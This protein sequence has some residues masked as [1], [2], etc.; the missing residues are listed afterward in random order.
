MAEKLVRIGGAS[1]FWGDTAY[2]AQ[3]LIEQAEIDYLVF[4][5]LAEITMSLLARAKARKPDSGYAPDFVA[6]LTPL[7]PKIA[8][9]GIKV[10]SNAG[11]VNP[12]ACRDA[13]ASKL[14]DAG[15]NL[16]VAVVLGDDISSMADTLRAE[17]VREMATGAPMPEALMSANAYLGARPIAQALDAGADIVITGRCVDSAVTLGPLMHEFGWADTDYDL[18]SAGSL[19]GHL[20]ECGPQVTG[21]LF[22]DWQSVP[23]WDDMG[24]PIVACASDGSF[25]LTKPDGTG[26]LV[27]PAS[28][29][30]QLVYE[31]GDPKAYILPDVVC[32][33]SGV[34]I[35]QAGADIVRVTGAKGR[36]ST[37]SYKVTATYP[38]GF[39][40][41]AT[42][43]IGGI[44]AEKKAQRVADALIARTRRLFAGR[45]LGDY[46]D[47]DVEIL[48][49]EATYG[50]HAR[51]QK[52]RE[53]IL[54]LAA[55]H[56]DKEALALFTREFLP[57]A[58]SMAPGI[59]GFAGGRPTVSPVVRLFSCLIDKRRVPVT[60]AD[61]SGA[62]SEIAVT[63]G[64]PLK[65]E[66]APASEN[67]TLT[68]DGPS[69]T[70]PLIALAHGR[71]GDKGDDANIGIIAR[72]PGFVPLLRAAL[73]EQ[74]VA[75]Y[76]AHILT[77]TVERYELPGINA[78]NFLLHGALGGGGIASLRYDPQGKAFA[79]MILDMPIAV[80]S[81][82]LKTG[83]LLA[84]AAR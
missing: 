7:L 57:S 37:P 5:Y 69:E 47:V 84:E 54:K 10:V 63:A 28:V 62:E 18:L 64:S 21:G 8:A 6:A 76:F 19:A 39:R 22:T 31:I 61:G 59:T 70:V 29:G 9:K 74:K 3:Q 51:T 83:G 14:A 41:I 82:W 53:V 11:G 35:E 77:G 46:R 66:T 27:S 49:A 24:F 44:D 72:D 40:S 65:A 23:G 30:E 48:G 16:K 17:D 79:Q 58:T 20:I 55:H 43:M 26:G 33:W 52:P 45:N 15:L 81:S 75:D 12:L 80:P 67:E 42:M 25:S 78:F 71:S 32:D 34:R 60:V 50:P 2:G 4:D 56:D 1:A 68:V 13:L 38:D 73:S 36:A